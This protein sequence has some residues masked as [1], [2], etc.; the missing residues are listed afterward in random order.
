[1][2][3]ESAAPGSVSILRDPRF[4]KAVS[5]ALTAFVG[6]AISVSAYFFNELKG[7]VEGLDDRL[8]K[9][10]NRYA[11]L[12]EKANQLETMKMDIIALQKMFF[13]HQQATGHAAAWT[14]IVNLKQRV[15][16]L[17]SKK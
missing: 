6:L 1:M 10:D 17:E 8:N 5:W 9:L 14:E 16:T 12:T 7:A 2:A 13:E 3:G 15:S 4:D 11:V